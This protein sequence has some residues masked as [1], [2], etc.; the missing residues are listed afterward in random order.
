MVDCR[1]Q[2]RDA[3]EIGQSIALKSSGTEVPWQGAADPCHRL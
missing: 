1:L 3:L 2:V